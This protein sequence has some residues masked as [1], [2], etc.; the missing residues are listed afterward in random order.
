MNS[1]E[2]HLW[3]QSGGAEI[4][5]ILERAADYDRA[6][7]QHQL[8]RAINNADARKRGFHN[9]E[10]MNYHDEKDQRGRAEWYKYLSKLQSRLALQNR[11]K[12]SNPI[13][14]RFDRE[15]GK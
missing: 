11:P 3:Q 6:Q 8:G 9:A 7:A 13:L 15:Y 1:I 5:Q 12:V 14:D 2:R 10:H 4:Q